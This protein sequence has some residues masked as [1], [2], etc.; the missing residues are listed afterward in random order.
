[1]K[2]TKEYPIIEIINE[3]SSVN[4]QNYN[5][6]LQFLCGYPKKSNEN[7]QIKSNFLDKIP[8]DNIVFEN[9]YEK[10]VFD[11]EKENNSNELFKRYNFKDKNRRFL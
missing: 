1:M 8:F 6:M 11:I 10:F 2:D 3:I 9:K 7:L 5:A 4:Y